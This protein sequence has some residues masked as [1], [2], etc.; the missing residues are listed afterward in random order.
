MK[1]IIIFVLITVFVIGA[2]S[3]CAPDN[4]PAGLI[5]Q[6]EKLV[7][8]SEKVKN[9]FMELLASNPSDIEKAEAQAEALYKEGQKIKEDVDAILEKIE[10]L[11]EKDENSFTEEQLE[12]IDELQRKV[13]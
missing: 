8:R 11:K 7:D 12:K 4:S 3:A 10:D 6:I 2:F 13:R 1:K 9:E 5:K